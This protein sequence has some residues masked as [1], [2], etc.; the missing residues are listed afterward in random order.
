MQASIPAVAA[1]LANLE[2]IK[3][4]LP[5]VPVKALILS[6]RLMLLG[7]TYSRVIKDVR[8]VGFMWGVEFHCVEDRE[9]VRKRA[10]KQ[11]LLLAPC[12]EK[13]IRI[14]PPINISSEDLEKCLKIFEEAV[15]GLA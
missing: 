2:A 9:R 15:A 4:C 6:S 11:G 14:C 1:S 12:G 7:G 13:T 8:G 3:L 5:D 10:Q